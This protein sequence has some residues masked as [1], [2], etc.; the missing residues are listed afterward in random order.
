MSHICV[1]LSCALITWANFANLSLNREHKRILSR[2][3][4]RLIHI[5]Y[6]GRPL[7][8]V[9]FSVSKPASRWHLPLWRL[10]T[11][12]PFKERKSHYPPCWSNIQSSA[13]FRRANGYWTYRCFREIRCVFL[14]FRLTKS[15]WTWCGNRIT[16]NTCFYERRRESHAD[17]LPRREYPPLSMG[18]Y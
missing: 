8:N 11:L 1:L 4:Y 14:I 6:G 7:F 2:L 3:I 13:G 17:W 9:S 10:D 16:R 12:H 5:Q 15:M 18:K